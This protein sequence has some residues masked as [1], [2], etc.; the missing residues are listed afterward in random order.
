M[1]QR[2]LQ[3][4]VSLRDRLKKMVMEWYHPETQGH[5]KRWGAR[6]VLAPHRLYSRLRRPTQTTL[7]A[8]S[9]SAYDVPFQAPEV[10]ERR[11]SAPDPPA[12]EQF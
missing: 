9:D 11:T 4:D 7:L 5:R 8:Q 3:D 6:I 12:M 2:R 10:M 1:K